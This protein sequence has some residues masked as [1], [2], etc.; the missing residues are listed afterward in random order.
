MH[1]LKTLCD[2]PT[3]MTLKWKTKNKYFTFFTEKKNACGK[4]VKNY[5]LD[6]LSTVSRL[7]KPTNFTGSR[8]AASEYQ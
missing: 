8:L 4:T 7:L 5:F 6:F 2:V 3:Q 1:L